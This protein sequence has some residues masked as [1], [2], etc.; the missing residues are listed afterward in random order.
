M[1]LND[2][3]LGEYEAKV[4][5]AEA[6]IISVIGFEF[7]TEIPNQSLYILFRH[8]QGRQDIQNLAKVVQLEAF[9]AGASLFYPIPVISLAALMF[10]NYLITSGV[11]RQPPAHQ[12]QQQWSRP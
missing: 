5:L 7:H 10:A 9:R 11:T 2:Q 6:N 12:R 4:A 3:K 1:F 8:F